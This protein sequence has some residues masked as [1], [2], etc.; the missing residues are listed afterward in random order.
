LS[1]LVFSARGLALP[2][3]WIR[4]F[5]KQTTLKASFESF[6]SLT[7]NITPLFARDAQRE[8]S[9]MLYAIN[10]NLSATAVDSR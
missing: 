9:W 2:C 5:F 8:G 7:H 1:L 6:A 10:I 4:A 3:E